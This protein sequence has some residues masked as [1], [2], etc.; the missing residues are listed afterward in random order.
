MGTSE[1]G[2]WAPQS[3]TARSASGGF[4]R[5]KCNSCSARDA[6]RRADSE[7]RR[8]R[9]LHPAKASSKN[10]GGEWPKARGGTSRKPE[11]RAAPAVPHATIRE[12]GTGAVPVCLPSISQLESSRRG[13]SRRAPALRPRVQ[14]GTPGAPRASNSAPSPGRLG[15][16]SLA[17]SS[18]SAQSG[19]QGGHSRRNHVSVGEGSARVHTDR[20]DHQEQPSARLEV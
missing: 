16:C 8:S 1:E 6:M 13:A 9:C 7:Q 10:L 5:Q 11:G 2:L 18:H 20:R 3:R 12:Q 17:G 4:I 14:G 15:P 19:T